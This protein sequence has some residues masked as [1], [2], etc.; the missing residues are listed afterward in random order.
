MPDGVTDHIFCTLVFHYRESREERQALALDLARLL[1]P[2]GTLMVVQWV[3]RAPADETLD[4]LESAGLTC[5][6]PS[7][8]VNRQYRMTATKPRIP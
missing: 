8:A 2:G 7:S 3:D 5:E 4:L 1:K 6:E